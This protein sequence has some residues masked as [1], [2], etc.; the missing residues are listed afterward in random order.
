[1]S[2]HEM[3]YTAPT[4]ILVKLHTYGPCDPNARYPSI[5]KISSLIFRFMALSNFTKNVNFR[6]NNLL[7]NPHCTKYISHRTI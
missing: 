4:Q 6:V 7:N 2:N 3:P 1:M 5:F